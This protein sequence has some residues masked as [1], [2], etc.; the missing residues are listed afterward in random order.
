MLAVCGSS[1]SAETPLDLPINDRGQD[2][3]ALLS[4][5]MT[6]ASPPVVQSV[7]TP[8]PTPLATP[9]PTPLSSPAVNPSSQTL[10][11]R[12]GATPNSGDGVSPVTTLSND[13]PANTPTT[14]AVA[15][16]SNWRGNVSADVVATAADDVARSMEVSTSTIEAVGPPSPRPEVQ[17]KT[18]SPPATVEPP[19]LSAAPPIGANLMVTTSLDPTLPA[20]LVDANSSARVRWPVGPEVSPAFVP[21]P[22]VSPAFVPP[23]EVSPAFVR[24][25]EVSPAF[26]AP[27]DSGAPSIDRGSPPPPP[28]PESPGPES[29][30][31]APRPFDNHALAVAPAVA[32]SA[33]SADVNAAVELTETPS[34]ILIANV[35]AGSPGSAR[36]SVTDNQTSARFP[37]QAN[38]RPADAPRSEHTGTTPADVP[39]ATP[40]SAAT[41]T[42]SPLASAA[43]VNS[44]A[45]QT[46]AQITA[47]S[48]SGDLAP[49][50]SSADL[51]DRIVTV[52]Q[53]VRTTDGTHRFQLEMHPGDLGAVAVD[54]TIDGTTVHVAMSAERAATTE[55]LRAALSELRTSLTAVGLH[56]GQLDVGT[57]RRGSSSDSGSARHYPSGPTDGATDGSFSSGGRSGQQEPRPDTNEPIIRAPY[58]TTR[59]VVGDVVRDGLANRLAAARNP[60]RVDSRG[61]DVQL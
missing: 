23:P 22:E 30:G 4:A 61:V 35:I 43:S 3:A 40:E 51:S 39:P 54:L 16:T 52:A 58:R 49:V 18:A 13:A 25:P 17:R 12:S 47:Q 55:I 15:L 11:E 10:G 19:V 34:T 21:E 31:A 36:V 33:G 14:V 38:E 56:A 27:V 6:M 57:D 9:L 20:S 50:R 60:R 59:D 32:A 41:T 7:S 24:Q 8:T 45:P 37:Q 26:V 1:S 2:F 42:A 48:V 29:F 5:M 53:R 44:T 46:N 28:G